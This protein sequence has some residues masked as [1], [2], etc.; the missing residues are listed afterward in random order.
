MKKIYII[1]LTTV[2]LCGCNSF[3][4]VTPKGKLIPNKVQDF[5]ELMGDPL[6]V[7]AAYPLMEMC[8]DLYERRLSYLLYLVGQWKGLYMAGRILPGRGRRYDLE[9]SLFDYIYV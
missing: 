1:V 3:L 2:L 8:S 6:N 7:S 5:D 9:R 4:D